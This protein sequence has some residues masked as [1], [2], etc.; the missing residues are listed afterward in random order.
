MSCLQQRLDEITPG[1]DVDVDGVFDAETDSQV[2]LFQAVHGLTVDGIVGPQTA[3]V[4]DIWN[5]VPATTAVVPVQAVVAASPRG[6]CNPNYTGCVP[7]DSDVDCAGGRGN[8]PS[9]TGRV[10]V[11]G[12]DVYDLDR[13]GDGIACE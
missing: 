5:P 4:L 9:Y 10:E 2:R 13:D 11:I 3:G 6:N 7:N 12:R 8:G 1:A